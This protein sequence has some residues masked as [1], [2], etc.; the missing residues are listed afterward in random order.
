MKPAARKKTLGVNV[1]HVATLRQ[2]RRG[3][4]PSVL[5]AALEAV[6]GGAEGITIHLREDRRHIQDY[7]LAAIR[8]HVKVPLNLEMAFVP[9]M[10]AIALKYRPQ[11]ICLVPERRRELTTEGG[12]DVLKIEKAL[13]RAMS[14]FAAAGIEVSL[15]IAPNPDQIRAAA[16]TGAPVIEI[17]TGAYAHAVGSARKREFVRIKTAA[18]LAA[19]LGLKVNAGHGL[20]YENVAP[21]V[22]LP[23]LEEFNIGHSIVSRSVF[24]GL[25]RA[26]R[27]MKRLIA[28]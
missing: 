28:A 6:K 21:L 23:E 17:H 10:T 2:A 24:I 4:E 15:F 11:K 13:T 7:D 20:N 3:C 9:E 14:R 25:E 22:R 26:V 18:R 27:E 5:Q 12:L 16:R 19:E 8:R 1:D